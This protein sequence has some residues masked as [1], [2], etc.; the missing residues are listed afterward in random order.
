[1]KN[2]LIKVSV[3]FIAFMSFSYHTFA[4]DDYDTIVI[5]DLESWTAAKFQ[6]KV[7][8]KLKFQVSQQ[9]RLKHNSSELER[10][11][12]QLKG[13]FSVSPNFSFGGG[14]RF[15]L[16]QKSDY[17]LKEH[18]L[19]LDGTY[20][21]KFDRF[22][23]DVRLRYQSVKTPSLN[24]DFSN[25]HLRGKFELEYNIKSWKL[26]PYVSS[27]IFR[28][29][30]EG[31]TSGYDKVRFQMGTTYAF[32]KKHSISAFYGLEKEL[33]ETYPKATYLLGVSYKFK[34]KLN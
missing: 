2:K 24:L 15:I 26:D 23:G 19:Q 22:K 4:Q 5:R 6:L 31:Y 16:E 17:L 11:F 32:N 8:D 33:N 9:L 10:T 7:N 28:Q 30:G 14:Y 18:R 29:V 25:N 27:E 1:M 3:V 12:T 34:L 20:S 13:V 21:F